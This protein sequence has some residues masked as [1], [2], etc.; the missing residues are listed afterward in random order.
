MSMRTVM[1]ARLRRVVEA[2]EAASRIDE[3]LLD[4]RL[5]SLASVAPRGPAR[6]RVVGP[7]GPIERDTFMSD[8]R[9]AN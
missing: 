5:A 8:Y 2:G 6:A 7:T 3:A 4:A 1:L 9:H